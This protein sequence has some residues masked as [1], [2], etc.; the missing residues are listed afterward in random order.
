MAMQ[1]GLDFLGL[2]DNDWK[3]KPTIK[4]FP[5][6][7][8]LGTFDGVFGDPY[9]KVLKL[10]DSGKVA[11][12][13][14]QL[15]YNKGKT[16]PLPQTVRARAPKWQ[17]LA[18]RNPS[19]PVVVSP[20]CEYEKESPVE[21]K[22]ILELTKELCPNC[23]VIQSPGRDRV[24]LPGYDVEEHG[25]KART[26][27][28]FLSTDGENC[29]DMCDKREANE[30]IGNWI[31][32]HKDSAKVCF[33]WGARFNLIEAHNTL[34]PKQRFAAPEPKY[35]QGVAAHCTALPLPTSA[36]VFPTPTFEYQPFLKPRLYKTFAEDQQGPNDP[37]ENNPC[38]MTKTKRKFVELVTWDNQRVVKLPLWP[39]SRP[40]DV[41][42]Y[43]HDRRYAWEL[44]QVAQE[45]SGCQV[46]FL[47]EGDKY[48][49]PLHAAHRGHF[50][51]VPKD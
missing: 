9:Q 45:K 28:Q 44:A 33:L 40:H 51:Q 6:G 21:L 34:N 13:R 5:Q 7:W 4:V 46:V 39:D 29:Y 11:G 35:I 27:A 47:K 38:I 31:H 12:V 49:G 17:A 32:R 26:G 16:L 18:L 36:W 10:V 43:Y 8:W 42:R 50:F 15:D 25:S 1:F 19:I 3:I 24:I 23:Q 22:M 48:F 30:G 20:G 2:A 41:E 37:R 14:I